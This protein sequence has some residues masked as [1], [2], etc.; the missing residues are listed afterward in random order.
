MSAAQNLTTREM[1][2]MACLMSDDSRKALFGALRSAGVDTKDE[3]V[4]HEIATE[5]LGIRV[6]SFTDLTDAQAAHVI[7][8]L[9]PLAAPSAVFVQQP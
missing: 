4:R 8:W 7:A 9:D 3:W 2:T 6:H 1:L 5:A